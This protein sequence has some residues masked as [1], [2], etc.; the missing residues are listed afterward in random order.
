MFAVYTR[1]S[2]H[3]VACRACM[4]AGFIFPTRVYTAVKFL[5]KNPIVKHKLKILKLV[6]M[7]CKTSIR[8]TWGFWKN[9]N[10]WIWHMENLPLLLHFSALKLKWWKWWVQKLF[11]R[12]WK[13]KIFQHFI[14]F[15]LMWLLIW[16]LG[17]SR[18]VWFSGHFGRFF[19]SFETVPWLLTCH[20]SYRFL[21]GI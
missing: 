20:C 14:L 21:T 9:L 10:S 18:M 12:F 4:Y 17:M 13:C 7:D 19:D 6:T 16:E 11:Y 1:V 2:L 15:G 5:T 3:T 8:V